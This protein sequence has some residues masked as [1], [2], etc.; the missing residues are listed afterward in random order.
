MRGSTPLTREEAKEVKRLL[1]TVG[2]CRERNHA[3]FCI[4]V[5]TGFRISELLSLRVG[6]LM[7]RDGSITEYVTVKAS[8]MKGGCEGRTIYFNSHGRA[9][10]ENYIN[11]LKKQRFYRENMPLFYSEQFKGRKIDRIQACKIL[12]RAFELA[13]VNGQLGTHVMRKTFANMVYD[14]ML[15]KLGDGKPIDAIRQTSKALGHT[16]VTNTELYLSFR[17]EE[18]RDT[19]EKVGI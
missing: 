19:L 18:I 5:N 4:G 2:R 16:S 9:I 14:S 13:E 7:N 17:D 8:D 15:E 11:W 6:D 3:L 12:N 10:A 1:M